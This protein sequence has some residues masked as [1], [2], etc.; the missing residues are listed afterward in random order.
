MGFLISEFLSFS[1]SSSLLG[2]EFVHLHSL[3]V[4]DGILSHNTVTDVH[5]GSTE[6]ILTVG[7]HAA[8][9][10]GAHSVGN[11]TLAHLRLVAL[12]EDLVVRV[13]SGGG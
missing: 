13:S 11:V 1:F 7:E 10:I 4:T 2:L 8:A 9:L 5:L 3:V 12:G 6:F